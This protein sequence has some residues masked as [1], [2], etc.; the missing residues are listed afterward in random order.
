MS[1]FERILVPVDFSECSDR[2]VELALDIA[3]TNDAQLILVHAV[4]IPPTYYAAASEGFALPLMDEIES[5]E[6][7]SLEELFERLKEK[8]P[9]VDRLLVRGNP[10]QKII[11]MAAKRDADL[12]VMGTQG[13]TG[14]AHV[15]LGSVAEKVIRLSPVPVLT[16]CLQGRRKS[17]LAEKGAPARA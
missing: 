16:A 17:T 15:F 5:A 9:K 13:R 14:L 12:I 6:K 11:E 3:R 8:H 1:T 10:W 2:A 7:A 4:H